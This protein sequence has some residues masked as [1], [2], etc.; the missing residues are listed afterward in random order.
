MRNREA[1]ESFPA[2]SKPTSG[3]SSARDN[4]EVTDGSRDAWNVHARKILRSTQEGQTLPPNHRRVN[5][6][7]I[8]GSIFDL[9]IKGKN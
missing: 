7:R 6:E 5:D 4:C 8:R 1:T 9:R 2:V 3:M